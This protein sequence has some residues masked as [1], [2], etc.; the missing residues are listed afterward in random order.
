MANSWT[1][2]V[3]VLL[4]VFMARSQTRVFTEQTFISGRNVTLQCGNVTDVKW[5]ELIYIVWNISLQGRKCWLGLSP[6]LDNTCNDGKRLYNTSDG[7]SLFIPKISIEDEGFYS[8]DVS[9]KGGSYAVNVTVN[10]NQLTTRLESENSLRIAICSSTSKKTEPTLHWEPALNYSSN[11]S[12][13][14]NGTSFIVVNRLYLPNE[15]NISELTCVATYKSES[16]SVQQNSTLHL[17]TGPK[18]I[19]PSFLLETIAITVGSV[20]FI[21]V[22]LAMVY[23]LRRKLYDL[24]AL[25]MLCCKSKISTTPE[26]KPPQHMSV[27]TKP[28]DVEEVEPYASYIQRVNSIYNSSAELFNA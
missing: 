15:V 21:L 11:N 9:Y 28:A 24:S 27:C 7:V 6:K 4:S 23:I 5:K 1:L 14:K 13:V 8:C 12:S 18:D 26:D 25:K 3:I 16:G 22:S 20:C 19:K 17:T 2:T 10:V